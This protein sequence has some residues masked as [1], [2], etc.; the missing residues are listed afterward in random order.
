MLQHW[1][2]VDLR[3]DQL[4]ACPHWLL[5]RDPSIT[6]ETFQGWWCGAG[7]LCRVILPAGARPKLRVCWDT[8]APVPLPAAAGWHP[9]MQDVD[10]DLG[11]DVDVDLFE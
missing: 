3:R 10:V 5:S 2:R 4:D 11:M 8:H 1:F 7:A 6:L 9:P